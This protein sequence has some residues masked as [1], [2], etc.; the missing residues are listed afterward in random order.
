MP[1]P[2]PLSPADEADLVALA[3]GR[4]DPARRDGV[5]ARV[6]AEP[7]LADALERQRAAVAAITAA[8]SEIS[9]PV[10]LRARIEK[11]SHTAGRRGGAR[12]RRSPAEVA[13]RRAHEQSMAQQ[14][15]RDALLRDPRPP[16]REREPWR[17]LVSLAALMVVPLLCVAVVTLV[18]ELSLDRGVRFDAVVAVASR[19]A[20]IAAVEMPGPLLNESIQGVYFPDYAT[21]FDWG[22]AGV[23]TDVVD[24]RYTRTVF[25][26]QGASRIAY[27]IVGGDVLPEPSDGD[28]VRRE[29]VFL[30]ALRRDGRTVVTWQRQGHTCVLSG[31]GVPQATLLELASWRGRGQVPF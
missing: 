14:H 9:A 3:D 16:W 15:A 11:L 25:Y 7:A 31:V 26:R 24:D 6:A 21:R 5:L 27:T 29:G 17:V 22:P 28:N 2:D 18:Q 10:A 30:R 23:R 4:L 8:T 12:A 13:R 19:P 1:E 20:E